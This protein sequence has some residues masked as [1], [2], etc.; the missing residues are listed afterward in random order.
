MIG[1]TVNETQLE[2]MEGIG[3]EY[4]YFCDSDQG[5]LYIYNFRFEDAW[6]N[7]LSLMCV[8]GFISRAMIAIA[9]A[10]L[11]TLTNKEQVSHLTLD[12]LR[13]WFREG[14]LEWTLVIRVNTQFH[15][16]E[17]QTRFVFKGNK[18]FRSINTSQLL[19][20]QCHYFIDGQSKWVD[21]AYIDNMLQLALKIWD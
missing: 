5:C 6:H 9:P 4:N 17:K 20:H 1:C 14:K 21:Q 16:V 7:E 19:H 12:H 10:Q 3:F 11:T 13:K 15:Q 18:L 8:P 2:D